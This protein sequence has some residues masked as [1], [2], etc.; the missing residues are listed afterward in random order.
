MSECLDD[1]SMRIPFFPFFGNFKINF[2]FE[3]W[4]CFKSEIHFHWN[5]LKRNWKSSVTAIF[6]TKFVNP[7]LRSKL[8]MMI[9]TML[10]I[11]SAWTDTRRWIS[12]AVTRPTVQTGCKT[13]RV[14]SVSYLRKLMKIFILIF[15]KQWGK[16][17]RRWGTPYRFASSRINSVR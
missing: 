1:L 11:I 12:I 3:L 15:S 2:M 4:K 13:T 14:A 7:W 8:T 16:V 6:N 10:S 5:Q 9:F 17:N